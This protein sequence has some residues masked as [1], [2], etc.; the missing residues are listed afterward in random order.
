EM[1]ERPQLESEVDAPRCRVAEV[2]NEPVTAHGYANLGLNSLPFDDVAVGVD[3]ESVG[4][5][6]ILRTYFVIPDIIRSV[7]S[8]RL[9]PALRVGVPH[10]DQLRITYR[11]QRRLAA[12]RP[13]ALR[14]RGV[15]QISWRRL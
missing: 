12:A 3:D 8:R 13:E 11:R 15:E 9:R 5:Q 4:E 1:L 10:D 2:I 7:G 14:H 6:L